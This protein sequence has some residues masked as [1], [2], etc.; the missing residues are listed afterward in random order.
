[1]IDRQGGVDQDDTFD[2]D[3]GVVG[4]KLSGD[5]EGEHTAKGPAYF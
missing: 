1:M 5:F 4:A 3:V 2:G